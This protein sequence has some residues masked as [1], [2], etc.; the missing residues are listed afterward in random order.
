[1]S[2]TLSSSPPI[3]GAAFPAGP[4][5]AATIPTRT[6]VVVIGGGTTGLVTA[7][8]L[9]RKGTKVVVVE[10]QGSF[11]GLNRVIEFAPGF[12]ATPM[13]SDLGWVPDE[14]VRAIGIPVPS[15][16]V[17][18]V[19]GSDGEGG[20]LTL[21]GNP[22]ATAAAIRR[23]SPRDAERWPA[24]AARIAHLSGFLERL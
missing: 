19:S 10:G 6:D 13:A 15:G 24:F 20:F 1:M 5:A 17:T 4:P 23:F 14:V 9:A 8:A 11:G 22:E 16:P 7:I 2:G 12:R 3:S 18:P 21:N